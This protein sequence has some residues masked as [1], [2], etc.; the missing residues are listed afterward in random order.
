M[1]QQALKNAHAISCFVLLDLPALVTLVQ[2]ERL[3][4]SKCGSLSYLPCLR[5]VDA[6]FQLLQFIASIEIVQSCCMHTSKLAF[7]AHDAF[8]G[9]LYT[10]CHVD[11]RDPGNN[12]AL[13]AASLEGSEEVVAYLLSL[14]AE[15]SARNN[16]EI[17][18][19]HYACARGNAA[20]VTRLLSAGAFVD[21]KQDDGMTALH[22]AARH[23][24]PVIVRELIS[25]NCD[26][27]A[28]SQLDGW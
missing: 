21:A 18:P 1:I 5:V 2:A 13:H 20:V 12:T 3:A 7:V 14:R 10:G 16:H 11:K 17:T 4:S 22:H 15:V 27:N 9:L 24:N 6:T 8:A 23:G 26:A 19:L 28:V 25:Y